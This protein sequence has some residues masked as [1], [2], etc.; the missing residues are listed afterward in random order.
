MENIYSVLK[1]ESDNYRLRIC[2]GSKL[3]DTWVGVRNG[4]VKVY[5]HQEISKQNAKKFVNYVRVFCKEN[6]KGCKSIVLNA[7]K[8]LCDK[9][10]HFTIAR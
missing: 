2:L 9:S 5:N 10:K 3:I 4:I 8:N 6:L 1:Q 7:N